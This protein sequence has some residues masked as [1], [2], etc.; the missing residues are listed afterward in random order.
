MASFRKLS[1]GKWEVTIDLGRNPSTGK[2]MRKFKSGFKT[3]KEAVAYANSFCV[4]IANGLNVI[5]NKVLLKDDI[6]LFSSITE[7][8]VDLYSLEKIN[9]KINSKSYKRLAVLN[10]IFLS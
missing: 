6:K 5:D 1:N 4:D 10:N 7:N 9:K 3:K 2:R 8:K